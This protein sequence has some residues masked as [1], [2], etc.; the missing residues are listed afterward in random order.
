ME[1]RFLNR[2][3][4]ITENIGKKTWLQRNSVK[5]AKISL[6]LWYEYNTIIS[7]KEKACLKRNFF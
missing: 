3:K 7:A 1:Q 4:K 2:K 5:N 6:F